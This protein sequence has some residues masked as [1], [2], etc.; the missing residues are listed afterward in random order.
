MNTIIQ[1][2]PD[3]P[4]VTVEAGADKTLL[5]IDEPTV[6][7]SYKEHGALLL[8]GFEWDVK[9]FGALCSKYCIGSAFNESEDRLLLDDTNKIQSVNGGLDSFPLPE[10]GRAHV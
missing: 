8:R 5:S 6:I 7:S 2:E 10:I 3:R 9:A 4:Y 1:P